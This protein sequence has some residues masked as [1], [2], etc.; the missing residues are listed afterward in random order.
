[1]QEAEI[2]APVSGSIFVFQNE[3]KLLYYLEMKAMNLS[4]LT[5]YEPLPSSLIYK[6]I[7][8]P[9]FNFIYMSKRF[10]VFC[11]DNDSRGNYVLPT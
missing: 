6:F 10:L 8:D 2:L 7:L 11:F 5:Y 3:K 4:L 9:F 1:M